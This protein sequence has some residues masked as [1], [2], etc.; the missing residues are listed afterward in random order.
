MA[1]ILI[2]MGSGTNPT[3]YNQLTLATTSIASGSVVDANGAVVS[4]VSISTPAPFETELP[5][6]GTIAFSEIPDAVEQSLLSSPT[7]ATTCTVRVS[8]LA[9]GTYS[10]RAFGSRNTASDRVGS[11]SLN[12][13]TGVQYSA[14]NGGTF[15][16]HCANDTVTLNGSEN[17]DIS[18]V[19]VT[20]YAIVNEIRISPPSTPAIVSVDGD[21]IITQGQQNID[22]VVNNVPTGEV[23]IRAGA[24]GTNG[25]GG[26]DFTGLTYVAGG[27]AGSFTV[28][29]DVPLGITVSTNTQCYVETL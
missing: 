2:N 1:D 14:T 16:S 8:G 23:P 28:T 13:R 19:R 11:M 22:I 24:H 4:G 18:F 7:T 6:G 25:V 9:A 27:T 10:V 5:T 20:S 26:T 29:A 15:A 21:N 12:G 17:L 3:G